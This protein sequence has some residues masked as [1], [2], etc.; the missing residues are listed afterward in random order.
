MR[1][2][3][4]SGKKA[5]PHLIVHEVGGTIAANKRKNVYIDT[6][7]RQEPQLKEA[8]VDTGGIDINALIDGSG[9]ALENL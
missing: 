8:S 3:F 4:Q 5:V 6:T 7:H 9:I 1:C 2:V